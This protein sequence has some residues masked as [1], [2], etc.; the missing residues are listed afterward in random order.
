MTQENLNK[1]DVTSHDDRMLNQEYFDRFFESEGFLMID[2]FDLDEATPDN[3][4][5]SL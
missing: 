4:G 1:Q 5:M 2:S 3:R